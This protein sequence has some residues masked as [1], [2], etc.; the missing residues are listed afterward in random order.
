MSRAEADVRKDQKQRT[1]AAPRSRNAKSSKADKGGSGMP[2]L[3]PPFDGQGAADAPAPKGKAA[4]AVVLVGREPRV[5]LLPTEVHV[6]RK[7]RA[8]ARRAWLGVIV[9]GVVV[10]LAIGGVTVNGLRSQTDLAGAQNETS[11]L[12]LQQ[13]K[14]SEVRDVERESTLIT[15]GQAVGGST[16]IDWQKYL[17]ELNASLPSGVS[18][19]GLSIDSATPLTTYVQ[20]TTPLQGQRIATLQIAVSSPTIPSVPDWTSGLSTL[21]GYVDSS[22]TSISREGT[23]DNY[24]ASITLHI[25]EKAYDGKYAEGK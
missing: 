22:I 1:S 18:I 4:A 21:T 19:T 16:E 17:T 7:E 24:T 11:A 3:R 8:T 20:A 2:P 10:V 14:Y 5:D 23:A 9:V 25:N 6:D 15:A 12:L 13:Q